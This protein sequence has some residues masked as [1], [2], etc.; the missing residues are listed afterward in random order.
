M[1]KNA[2]PYERNDRPDPEMV[3]RSADIM[4]RYTE[5]MTKVMM[6]GA[7]QQQQQHQPTPPPPPATPDVTDT[8]PPENPPPM[9]DS[10]GFV[11]VTSKPKAKIAIDG[12]D[13]GMTTPTKLR[14]QAGK[15]KIQFS[16]GTTKSAFPLAVKAGETMNFHKDL[17]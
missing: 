11:T 17:E 12:I 7:Q 8:M 13:S 9:N 1:A 2:K 5:C 14:L 16:Y 6:A 10:M 4:Q 3:K 15:H